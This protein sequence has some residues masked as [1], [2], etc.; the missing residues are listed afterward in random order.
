MQPA[1]PLSSPY[2]AEPFDAAIPR[3]DELAFD[4]VMRLFGTLEAPEIDEL[5]GEYHARL[6][7]N[8]SRV[9]RAIWQ[10]TLSNPVFPA[11]GWAR[12]SA[13]AARATTSFGIEAAWSAGF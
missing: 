5:N 8:P 7:A 9:R 12:R 3:P 13:A 10:A 6:L 2:T 1:V 11:P 4:E